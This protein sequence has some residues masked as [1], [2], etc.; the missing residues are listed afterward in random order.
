MKSRVLILLLLLSAV[1]VSGC[2]YAHIRTPYDTDLNRSPMGDKTGTSSWTGILW[3]VA[4]GDGSSAAAARDGGITT[5]T[6][7]DKEILSILFGL[8]YKETTIVYGYGD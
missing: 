4:W 2:V 1:L 6:Q 7:M 5:L 3:A 8:Y